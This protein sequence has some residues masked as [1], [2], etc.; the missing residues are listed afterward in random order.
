MIIPICA[1]V[2]A[3]TGV[4]KR[5][6]GQGLFLVSVKQS[7]TNFKVGN[8]GQDVYV[9]QVRIAHS[10]SQVCAVKVK[11]FWLLFCCSTT[12]PHH[13]WD[14]DRLTLVAVVN[15]A[16]MGVTTPCTI[17][18]NH[19]P[20]NPACQTVNTNAVVTIWL[21]GISWSQ[22]CYHYTDFEAIYLNH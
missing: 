14:L 3:V 19:L 8:S 10:C 21:S 11:K 6:R 4:K 5:S 7:R 22:L 16:P 1:V 18:H 15:I 20:T 9:L 2:T 12:W 13:K 17:D